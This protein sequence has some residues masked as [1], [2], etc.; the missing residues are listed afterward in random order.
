VKFFFT[1]EAGNIMLGIGVSL[2]VIGY[3]VMKKIVNIEV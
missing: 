1:D 3:L 2:Q